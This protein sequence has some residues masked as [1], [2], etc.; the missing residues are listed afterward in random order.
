LAAVLAAAE[1]APEEFEVGLVDTAPEDAPEDIPEGECTP[2]AALTDCTEK[3][4]GKREQQSTR[5]DIEAG[6]PKGLKIKVLRFAIYI[7]KD[8]GNIARGQDHFMVTTLY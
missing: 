5:A 1:V 4:V 6:P 8:E 7:S 2:E 3:I